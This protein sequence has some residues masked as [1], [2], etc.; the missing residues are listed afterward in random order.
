MN[1]AYDN[2]H[3][4]IEIPSLTIDIN[5]AQMEQECQYWEEWAHNWEHDP[6]F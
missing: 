1:T 3:E 2:G 4:V 6:E 5:N